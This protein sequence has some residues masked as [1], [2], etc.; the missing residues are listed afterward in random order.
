MH[1]QAEARPLI[2]AIEADRHR[3]TLLQRALRTVPAEI[4]V[5]ET[6]PAGIDTLA[7]RIPDAILTSP[8]LSPKDD[9]TIAHW[10]RG[11]GPAAAHVQTL[12]AP[13]LADSGSGH[14]SG[15]VPGR[16][17]DRSSGAN[18]EGCDPAVFAAQVVEYLSRTAADRPPGMQAVIGREP[19]IPPFEA[20]PERPWDR[21][22]PDQPHVDALMRQLNTFIHQNSAAPDRGGPLPC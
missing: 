12:A 8:F 11:L 15:V 10:L 22:D 13:L 17:R 3:T 1:A 9:S 5:A 21:L 18:Q 6:A 19:E 14:P 4:V 2:L 7:G 20:A 16:R